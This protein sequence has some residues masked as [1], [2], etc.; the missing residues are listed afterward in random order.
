MSQ[1]FDGGNFVPLAGHVKWRKSRGIPSARIC[2]IVQENSYSC[3]V[4]KKR[5]FVKRRLPGG[6][7]RIHVPSHLREITECG[8]KVFE[9]PFATRVQN[10]I[11][12]I[13]VSARFQEFIGKAIVSSV[14]N[15]HHQ[16]RCM[17]PACIHVMLLSQ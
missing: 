7:A 16:W 14:A 11:A 5:R 13:W 1:R 6:I 2:I 3:R 12:D 15:S 10:R 4:A 17:T 9:V 8:N